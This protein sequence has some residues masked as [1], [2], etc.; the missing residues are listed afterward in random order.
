MPI[1]FDSYD[2]S[3]GQIDLTEG[4]NA[5]LILSFL[6]EHPDQGFTPSEI[7]DAMD[8]AYGSVG[9]TLARLEKRGLVRHKPPYWALGHDDHLATYAGM[10][11]TIEAIEER[12]GPEDPDDWLQNAEPVEDA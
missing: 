5:Y 3:A 11:S 9:P 10:H 7:H 6:A 1:Q 2:E 8:I 12:F 4:S